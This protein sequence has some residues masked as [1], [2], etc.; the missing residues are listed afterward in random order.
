MQE[1]CHAV[2][3]GVAVCLSYFNV[4][5]TVIVLAMQ[6]YFLYLGIK[7]RRRNA[8]IQRLSEEGSPKG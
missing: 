2:T 5:A 6:I 3:T 8:S 1:F 7:E 4:I